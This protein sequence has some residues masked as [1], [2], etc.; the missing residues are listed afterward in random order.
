MKSINVFRKSVCIALCALFTATC[1]CAEPTWTKVN[2]TSSTAFIGIVKINDYDNSFPITVSE[3]DYIGAFVGD[4]CRM[5]AKVFA[6]DGKLYVSSVIQGGEITDMTSTTTSEPEEVEFKV[7]NHTTNKLVDAQVKGTLFTRSAGEIF[8]YEIGKPNSGSSLKSLEVAS[9]TLSPTFADDVTNY[10]ISVA[11]GTE[12]PST[13]D[14]DAVAADSRAT[15]SVS[16]ATSYDSEGKAKSTVTVTAEDGTKTVYNVTFVQEDCPASVPELTDFKNLKQCEGDAQNIVAMFGGKSDVAVWY[17]A[18]TGGVA[19]AETNDYKHGKTAAGT[20]TYY[21]ARNDGT[22]ESTDRLEVA[23]SIY[24]KP[25]PQILSLKDTYCDNEGVVTLEA[26]VSGGAFTLNGDAATSFDPSKANSG[27]N[28]I[29]YTVVKDGCEGSDSKTVEVTTQ[30]TVSLDVDLDMCSGDEAQTLKA[31]PSTGEWTGDGVSKSGNSYIFTPTKSSSLVYTYTE[32]AC[33]VVKTATITV[34][35]TPSPKING[36]NDAYCASAAAVTLSAEPVGGAFSLNGSEITSFNPADANIG[37]NTISYSVTV[38]GCKGVAS[39]TVVVNAAPTIDLSG[40]KT[41]VCTGAEVA[42]TPT[43]GVWKGTGVSGSTFSSSADGTYTLTY[44]ETQNGCSASE[45]VDVTVLNTKAPTVTSANVE[46]NGAVPALQALAAGT[47]NWYESLTG[48][49]LST[50]AKYTPAVSTATETVYTYYV[51]NTEKGCE[52]EKVPVTLTVTSCTTEAPTI[53]A[54]DAV[55]EGSAFPTLTAVGTNITWYDAITGGTK[56]E[57]GS[58]YKPTKEGTYYASQNPSCEGPRAMVKVDVKAK[59]SAPE[60]QGASSCEGAQLVAMTST[61]SVNWYLDKSSAA[62]ATDSKTYTPTSL[63]KTTTFYVNRTEN[64]CTSDFSEVVYSITPKPSAPVADVRKICFGNDYDYYVR[65]TGGTIAGGTLQWYNDKNLPLGTET[66]QEVSVPDNVTETTII[67]YTVSQTVDGC[68]SSMATAMLYVNPLPT[69]KILDLKASYCS[70]SNEKVT[71]ASDL[72]G[73]DFMIDNSFKDSF[74]PSQ[75]SKGA[76]KVLYVYEDKNECYGET[77]QVFSVEDCSAPDVKILTLNASSL[78]LLKNQDYSDFIV[79]IQP[80]DAPQ[81]V[82]W[83]SSNPSAV[84]V[85]TDGTLHAVGVGDAIITVTST[86]TD[87]KSAQCM[88]TVIA[89]AEAVTFTNSEPL[90]VEE[91]GFIDLSKFMEIKPEKASVESVTWSI[92][93][94]DATISKDGVLA[95][96]I[97]SADTDVEVMVK[98]TSVDGSTVS[99]K[100]TVTIVK[101][102]SLSA[103]TVANATQSICTGDDAVTFSATGDAIADWI[104]LDANNEVIGDKNTFTT[105]NAGTYY[106]Y[107]KFGDCAGAKTKVTLAVNALP[108]VSVSLASSFCSD[109]LIIVNLQ[110]GQAGGVFMVDGK[111]QDSFNPSEMTIGKHTVDYSYTDA[112]GCTGT[113]QAVFTIDDCSLPPVTSVVLNETSLTMEK[114]E[115][116]VLTTTIKPAESPQTVTWKSSDPTVATVDANGKIQAVGRGTATITATSTYTASQSASCTVTVLSPLSSVSFAHEGSIQLMEGKSVNLSQYL[117]INP[118]DAV[119]QSIVWSSSS[120][121]VTVVDGRAT[122][123][124]VAVETT[125]GVTVTVTSAEGTVK[126]ATIPVVVSPFTIDLSALNK[127]IIE[128][129][130]TIAEN[131]SK[132]G[133]NVGNIPPASF[134]ILQNAINQANELVANPPSEQST[135]DAQTI[136]LNS[137]IKD[138]LNSEIPN[139][140]TDISFE[141]TVVHLVVGEEFIPKAMFAPQGAHSDLIWSSSN[142]D[143]VRVYGSGKVVAQQP[144]SVAV[145]AALPTNMTIS[146]RI[147]I[148]VSE[149]PKLVSISMN[150]LGNQLEFLF[151]EKMAEPDPEVYTDLYAYG[152]DVAIYNVMDIYVDKKNPK[153]LIAVIGGFIDDPTDVCV[154][155]KGNSI[156][157]VDGGVASNFEYFLGK[158]AVN[159]VV[160][161]QIIAYPSIATTSVTVAGISAGDRVT[162]VSINGNVVDSR[163]ATGDT[164]VI[165]TSQLVAGTYYVIVYKANAIVARKGFVKK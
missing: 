161:D 108:K 16:P 146:A 147:I 31:T 138:F 9:Y 6:Y 87:S 46:V 41:E 132:K 96:G 153:K 75:M 92:V 73:G 26:S 109:E 21:V 48:S 137:A 155:Y 164:E 99:G 131:E 90:T 115:S 120:N 143:V 60:V 130:T 86:Y 30:P 117:V 24:E 95:A 133:V 44:T 25:A 102:C 3:G 62:V 20:Y 19:L 142:S 57:L 134:E 82:S 88:V 10:T 91:G 58:S 39:K 114:G 85:D 149:A 100:V 4:E 163:I 78:T 77:E 150:K 53:A 36:L 152:N 74:I 70:D 159:D 83:S 56:L 22:C 7:W 154:I 126:T 40:I 61:E 69:P 37:E 79:T 105:A 125:V 34:A 64:G 32:G 112:N 84:T 129:M 148:I 89:P 135:V 59:P 128:A 50:G 38:S 157:S 65:V 104:W 103:P 156:K 113:T 123:G 15:V 28:V 52:S 66:I 158:T 127:K 49:S 13:S 76:H 140:V 11:Y 160:S 101:S 12:L 121:A 17:A 35:T 98:V 110:S 8:D 139:K 33:S 43:T 111:K 97:V 145:T 42:L 51:S 124:S 80:Q 27:A 68:A 81:T 72:Q 18:K 141:E 136:L 5:N 29:E 144:G 106:V 107:Q 63:D 165:S 45:S 67:A 119:I 2:Y 55:C 14:F 116:T 94:S 47:I 1:V 71:L 122:A 93:S 151:T 23:L 162:V 118:S 54:V